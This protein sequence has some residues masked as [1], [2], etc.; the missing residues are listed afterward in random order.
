MR[1]GVG[2]KKIVR[3]L[4]TRKCGSC[5]GMDLVGLF[6]EDLGNV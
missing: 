3:G 5:G 4:R 1:G 6:E 2:V